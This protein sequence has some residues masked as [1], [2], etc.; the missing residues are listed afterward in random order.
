MNLIPS[1]DKS[2]EKENFARISVETGEEGVVCKLCCSTDGILPV[3]TL[4]SSHG[5][6][7]HYFCLLFSSGLGQAG[8]EGEGLKGFLHQ[9]INREVKRG[10]RLKC[11]YCRKKGATVGCA[12]PKCKKSYHLNCGYNHKALCQFYD[13][14]K[15]YCREHRPVQRV[16]R[17]GGGG[18]NGDKALTEIQCAVCQEKVLKKVSLQT[19]VS[20]C[21]SGF[22]HR[23]CVQ[24]QALS[25]VKNNFRCPLCNDVDSWGLEMRRMGIYVPEQDIVSIRESDR[26]QDDVNT[27]TSCHAKLCF[28]AHERGRTHHSS[29]LWEVVACLSC[30]GGGIHAACGGLDNVMEPKWFCYKCRKGMREKKG[31]EDQLLALS[32]KLWLERNKLLNSTD[33]HLMSSMLGSDSEKTLH[34]LVYPPDKTHTASSLQISPHK[35]VARITANTSF[36]DL[37]G[38]M[39]DGG[40]GEASP[41]DSDYESSSQDTGS[42]IVLSSQ[43]KN[44]HNGM[45]GICDLYRC[46]KAS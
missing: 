36:T 23:T 15:S 9:D 30:G 28:C 13:Q 38:C 29:G 43:S 45:K 3:D 37:L 1:G 8:G 6:T 27:S 21:C 19:L 14:F 33:S 34:C 5:I 46:Q 32:G 42:R 20:P 2:L 44:S 25:A 7:S 39:L 12:E 35:K 40:E 24:S 18:K 11:V 10:A 41:G 17:R 26:T 16:Q 4:L 22:L 31:G